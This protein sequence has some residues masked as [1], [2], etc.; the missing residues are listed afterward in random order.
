VKGGSVLTTNVPA[1]T[2]WGPPASQPLG[3]V[4]V[5][6][7]QETSYDEFVRGLRPYRKKKN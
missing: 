4:T 5:P 6:L 3:R 7:T 2:L 1:N